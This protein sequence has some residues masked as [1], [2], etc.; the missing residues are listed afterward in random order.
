MILP[1]IFALEDY[2]APTVEGAIGE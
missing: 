1:I 2:E